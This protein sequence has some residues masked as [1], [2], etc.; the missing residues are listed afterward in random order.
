[1]VW[2]VKLICTQFSWHYLHDIGLFNARGL[3]FHHFTLLFQWL[4]HY[5]KGQ[6]IHLPLTKC[7]GVFVPLIILAPSRHPM[8]LNIFPYLGFCFLW[9]HGKFV[10]EESKSLASKLMLNYLKVST[11]S[12]SEFKSLKVTYKVCHILGHHFN[13]L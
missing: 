2:K 11:Y 4:P 6:N 12:I 7:I 8:L 10:E 5:G 9:T 13:L 1:L 3:Q